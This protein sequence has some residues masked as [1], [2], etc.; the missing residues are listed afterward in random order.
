MFCIKIPTFE[1]KLFHNFYLQKAYISY[2]E[3][4]RNDGCMSAKSLRKALNK[5]GH[6]LDNHTFCELLRC[7]TAKN[8]ALDLDDFFIHAFQVKK[9]FKEESSQMTKLVSPE[10][11]NHT[12]VALEIFQSTLKIYSAVLQSLKTYFIR[13]SLILKIIKQ[14]HSSFFMKRSFY[15]ISSYFILSRFKPICT[16]H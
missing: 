12:D 1:F 2:C 15:S 14:L 6:F 16:T 9:K 3:K 8:A 10:E 13:R 11:E 5:P 7:Y 4:A